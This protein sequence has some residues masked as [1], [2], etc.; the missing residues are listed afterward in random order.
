QG[1]NGGNGGNATGTGATGGNGGNGG[2]ATGP[3]AQGG[4]GG[5]GGNAH[6]PGATGGNGGNG[7]NAHGP[8]AIGGG[9]CGGNGGNGGNA[10]GTGARGGNGG[11][12]G[13]CTI[14][15]NNTTQVNNVSWTM[16][17]PIYA[18]APVYSDVTVP[19]VQTVVAPPI[20]TCALPF[21]TLYGQP[22]DPKLQPVVVDGVT[23]DYLP[24]CQTYTYEPYFDC[25]TAYYYYAD[26]NLFYC[27]VPA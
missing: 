16:P 19:V 17:A 7:G 2:N 4:N 3:G 1:G 6:G 22:V 21:G 15:V 5:N 25:A 10:T 27:V 18:S 23:V 12:G 24:L 20:V 8:G 14:V 26:Q 11:N 9:Q 13:D